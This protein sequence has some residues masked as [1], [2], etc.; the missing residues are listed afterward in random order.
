M[1]VAPT[2]ANPV[3]KNA[4]LGRGLRV[5]WK[6]LP[7]SQSLVMSCP[8]HSILYEGTR[9]PGKTDSQIMFFRKHVG[10]GYGSFWRGV[11]FDREYKNLDD[12]ISKSKRWFPMFQDGARFIASRSDYKWVWPTGEELLFRQIKKK[13]DYWNYHGQEFPFIGWNELSKYPTSELFDEMMSCN[14]SSFR[15]EDFPLPD[16]K[17]GEWFLPPIPLVVFSTTNPYGAGHNWVKKRFIDVAPPGVVVSRTIDV[18]NPMTQQREPI[19][20]T[21]VR[22]FGSYKENIYLS[23]EY[24]AELEGIRDKNKRKAWLWGDW[25]VVAGGAVDDVWDAS[26]CVKPRFKVPYSWPINRSFDWGSTHPFSVGWWAEANG[27]YA[28]LPDGTRWCP[29]AGSLVRI[30]EWYGTEEVGTNRGLKMSAGDIAKGIVER[31]KELRLGRYIAGEVEAGPADGQIYSVR[32]KDVDTIATK[33]SDHGIDWLEADKSPGSRINGL[34][35]VRDM[36]ENSCREEGPGLYFTDNCLAT[37]ATVPVLPRDE[38]KMDD[39]D[40][41]AEDHIYDDIRY[42]VLAGSNRYATV[43]HVKFGT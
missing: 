21:Q 37:L 43:I 5:I 40:T 26:K 9:G 36:L 12:L 3:E 28:T 41:D 19:T 23:P 10:K 1:V 33:M 18:F 17:G 39:V 11:I 27:E 2:P 16:G 15:P 38:D 7:G 25:D 8:C 22:I 31:E 20:K 6:P 4:L 42:R 24:I 14:R 32:E 13:S 35:L 29:P 30:A 34:Q